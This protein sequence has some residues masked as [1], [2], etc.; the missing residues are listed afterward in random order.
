MRDSSRS[1]APLPPTD[2]CPSWGATRAFASSS[3][4]DAASISGCSVEPR[5][6]A[7]CPSAPIGG[8]PVAAPTHR[9]PKPA[10]G[11]ASKSTCGC[12]DF[13]WFFTD[14]H[15]ARAGA[16]ALAVRRSG[17]SRRPGRSDPIGLEVQGGGSPIAPTWWHRG[18]GAAPVHA[19]VRD[20]ASTRVVWSRSEGYPGDG[21]YLEFHKIRWPGGLRFWRVTGRGVDL[22]GKE[23]YDVNVGRA[24]AWRDGR[25]FASALAGV[26]GL[27]PP[28]WQG[29]RRSLR[30]RTVRAL[31]VRGGGLPRR[32]LPRDRPPG[33]GA[34]RPRPRSTSED[35]PQARR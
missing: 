13:R 35:S 6:A 34:A 7:G 16:V 20:P 18:P 3:C 9:L 33:C 28:W 5:A 27:L 24:R 12:A 15:L 10:T 14:S 19:L 22:G 32:H 21:G 31:V 25:H 30:Y 17:L 11:S 4:S 8:G 26:A 2:S 23:Q 29:D 1:W